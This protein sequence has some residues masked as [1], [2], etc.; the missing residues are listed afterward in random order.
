M[1]IEIDITGQRFGRLVAIRKDHSSW[2]KETKV[3]RNFWLFKCDCGKEKVIDKAT[4]VKGKVTSCGCLA[5]ERRN[6]SN[7][8]HGCSKTRLYRI[9]Q[10]MKNR[11]YNPS[12]EKYKIYGA[13]GIIVCEDWKN[14]FVSFSNWAQNNGYGEELTLDRIDCNGNYCPENCRWATKRE[15]A[16]NTRKNHKITL[17]GVTKNLCEWERIYNIQPALYHYYHRK[18]YTDEQIFLRRK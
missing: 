3:S 15:Q 5:I 8:T 1:S 2:N 17:N 9:W 10:D 12:R 14:D 18:G 11:C 4:V 16:N 7:T 13:R 6:K